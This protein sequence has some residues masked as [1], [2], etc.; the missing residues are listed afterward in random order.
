MQEAIGGPAWNGWTITKRKERY[1]MNINPYFGNL[2]ENYLFSTVS[3]KTSAYQQAHPEKQ[4]L[5]LSIGDVTRP[6][7]PAAVQAMKKAAE[8]MGGEDSFRGYGPEQGY[9]FLRNAVAGYYA[10]RGVSLNPSE[11]FISDGAKSD[12]GN[13]LEIFSK[14]SVS[15]I[16]DPVYPA[17]VDAN[18]MGGRTV[19]YLKADAENGFLPGPDPDVKADLI[20]LCSPNNPTGAAY[21]RQGLREWVKYALEREAVLLFDAAYE[22][23]IGEDSL[24]HSIYEMEGAKQCAIEIGSFSKIAGFTGVRCG[25]TI[26]PMELKRQ[27]AS[28]HRLWLRRQSTKFNGTPYVVQRAAEAVLTEEGLRQVQENLQYYKR[29]AE[30]ICRT[31]TQLQI[32]FTGG[33]NAPYVWMACPKGVSSWEYFD[34]LLGEIQVVGTPGSGFGRQGEG[35]FRL[36]AFGSHD[37]TREAMRRLEELSSR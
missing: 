27:G 18:I 35:Y 33:H 34:R 3:R 17:Y 1:R 14:D 9:E 5:K 24:P 4:L 12:L 21:T 15:L 2:E 16:P 29:N 13:I 28:L 6:L 10:R 32:P 31:L 7:C 11:I 25:Y 23:F 8:E 36:S 19:L 30:M 22:A 26:I 37:A 20:Y